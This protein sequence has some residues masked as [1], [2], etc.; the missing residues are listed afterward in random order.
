MKPQLRGEFLL[1]E[2]QEGEG[3]LMGG[4]LPIFAVGHEDLVDVAWQAWLVEV[5]KGVWSESEAERLALSGVDIREFM[6]CRPFG[7]ALVASK[8]QATA[9][10]VSR[11]VS[12]LMAVE[13]FP[14][15][16]DALKLEFDKRGPYRLIDVLEAVRVLPSP[17]PVEA[18]RI[19]TVGDVYRP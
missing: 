13:K 3:V 7:A 17:F 5:S 15:S 16:V 11:L 10:P 8:A 14:A 18:G 1:V 19:L 12:L 4:V 2:F 9:G 6:P